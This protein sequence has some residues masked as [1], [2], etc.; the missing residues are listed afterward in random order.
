MEKLLNT[1][2][3]TFMVIFLKNIWNTRLKDNRVDEGFSGFL[4]FLFKE[5]FSYTDFDLS[6][7]KSIVKTSLIDIS[8]RLSNCFSKRETELVIESLIIVESLMGYSCTNTSKSQVL[9]HV[10]NI[11]GRI[12]E[13]DANY[14]IYQNSQGLIESQ[15]NN[16]IELYIENYNDYKEILVERLKWFMNDLSPLL[17]KLGKVLYTQKKQKTNNLKQLFGSSFIYFKPDNDLKQHFIQA[18]FEGLIKDFLNIFKEV[19][20][21]KEK[22]LKSLPLLAKAIFELEEKTS[23][24]KVSLKDQVWICKGYHVSCTEKVV[25]L[26]VS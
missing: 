22:H 21:L 19:A 23:N 4:I 11:V 16:R 24:S 2:E 12:G 26:I 18:Y 10:F 25:R 20:E 14:Y 5:F 6:L 3:A 17:L 15:I 7:N 9:V 8:E 13:N 1:N